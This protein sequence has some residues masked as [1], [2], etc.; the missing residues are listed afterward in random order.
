M[1]ASLLKVSFIGAQALFYALVLYILSL[2]AGLSAQA[3]T[4]CIPVPQKTVADYLVESDTV[5]LAR[6]NPEKLWSYHIA[7]VIQGAGTEQPIEHLVSSTFR[8][9]LAL[10][11]QNGVV[12]A[13]NSSKKPSTWVSL[14]YADEEYNFFIRDILHNTANWQNSV[15][16]DEN[17]MA[18]FA[19]YLGHANRK[20]HQL[21]YIEIGRASYEQIRKYGA[22]WPLEQIRQLLSDFSYYEWRPLAIILLAMN[23]NANDQAYIIERFDTIAQLGQT[24]HLSAWAT[25]VVEIE[26]EKGI[27]RINSLYFE[28]PSRTKKEL[29]AVVSALSEHGRNGHIQL[30]HHVIDA[31]A[32]LLQNHANLAPQISRD[33]MQW[34]NWDFA[35]PMSEILEELKETDPLAAQAVRLY[36]T[37]AKWKKSANINLETSHIK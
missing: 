16:S 2:P 6:E 18:F 29:T 32:I 9:L 17:R 26:Q 21:A 30:R 4:I 11:P 12:F 24:G 23:G 31:Y 25:A 22:Q 3:C 1:K 14:G 13:L 36:V 27:N 33:L 34:Q 8:R 10:Y 5:V 37:R 19:P 20:L 7:E 15:E 28:N 35:E